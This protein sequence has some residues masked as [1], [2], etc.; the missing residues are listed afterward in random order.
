MASLLAGL[1]KSTDHPSKD[2]RKTAKKRAPTRQQLVEGMCSRLI[3]AGLCGLHAGSGFESYPYMSTVAAKDTEWDERKQKS[4]AVTW[5][6]DFSAASLPM[7]TLP[8]LVN[9]RSLAR[10]FALKAVSTP[11]TWGEEVLSSVM[12]A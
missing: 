8:A 6:V 11:D 9:E 10:A 5:Q 7:R 1:T 4:R 2:C 3:L 12:V